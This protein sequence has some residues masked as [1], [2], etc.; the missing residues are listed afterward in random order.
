MS[1][2]KI[3][4]IKPDFKSILKIIG[5]GLSLWFLYLIREILLIVLAASLLSTIISPAV[6][7]L[8]K[9]KL[10][11]WLG[12]FFV[13][14]GMLLALA[15]IFSAIVPMVI[16][17]SRL[18]VQQIPSVINSFFND[19]SLGIQTEVSSFLEQWLETSPLNGGVVFSLLG[20]VAGQI[21]SFFTILLIGFYLTV[22][23][24][25]KNKIFVS[26]FPQR[27]QKFFENFI[28]SSKKQIGDWGRG[29][30][31]LSLFVGI[32]SY[33]G[34]SIL[35]VKFALTLA[36]VAALTEAIPYIGPWLGAIPAVIIA[37]LQS[38]TLALLVI[39]LYVV[40][41]QVENVLLTPNI[42]HRAVGLDPLVIIVIL[43][44]GGKLAGP[45]GM[46]LAVPLATICSIL[47]REYQKYK[48]TVSENS[49]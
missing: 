45:L 18:F 13:F 41:Q 4:V 32:L 11:R 10:P 21:F 27:Y 46:I 9:K 1:A 36:L 26:F 16:S 14:L 28:D 35:G 24:R 17:Q 2:E 49:F 34:L 15:L 33:L 30:L 44:I 19:L 5:I 47:V 23:D 37:F 40:I 12:A 42:M 22:R 38:P 29:L 20:N 39:I 3:T 43:L 6:N 7:Y 25:R 8:E 48:K 31:S